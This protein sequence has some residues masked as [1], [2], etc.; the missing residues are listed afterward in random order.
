MESGQIHIGRRRFWNLLPR[1]RA[2][3]ASP[4][5][6]AKILS[7][8]HHWLDWHFK[9][10]DQ[11]EMEWYVY[12]S[13]IINA[14]VHR[15]LYKQRK[16]QHSPHPYWAP[17]YGSK[18]Q[19]AAADDDTDRLDAKTTTRL[20]QIVG[21]LLYYARVV[22]PIMLVALNSISSQQAAPTQATMYQLNQ[23]LDYAATHPN[24][25]IEYTPSREWS[26][27]CIRMRRIYQNQEQEAGSEG[28]SI[29]AASRYKLQQIMDQYTRQ[30]AF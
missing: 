20:Q 9:L 14:R 29:W 4:P 30:P 25:T 28:I 26:S 21:S 27:K 11:L 22:D 13:G 24:A 18:T 3:W 2:C 19:T 1:E 15:K 5:G 7:K 23:L 8:G 17:V 12:Q 6:L 16:Q 10:R